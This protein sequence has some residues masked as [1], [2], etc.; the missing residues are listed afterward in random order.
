MIVFSDGGF[1]QGASAEDVARFAA[2]RGIA[3]HA[4]GIGDPSPPRNVR[5]SELS[6]PENVFQQ[7][8]FSINARFA[9]EGIDGERL[10]VVLQEPQPRRWR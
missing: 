6:A 5:V 10:R 3:I 9:N 1:N 8:P 7:D 4:V 2:E